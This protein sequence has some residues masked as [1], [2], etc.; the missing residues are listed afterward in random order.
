MNE[1][2]AWLKERYCVT[3]GKKNL[4]KKL[5]N[6]L[7]NMVEFNDQY[8]HGM[9]LMDLHHKDVPKPERLVLDKGEL[10]I[11]GFEHFCGEFGF[12]S[13]RRDIKNFTRPFFT[14]RIGNS[15]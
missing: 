3:T 11:S 5:K 2:E 15:L 14:N 4:P 6:L 9:M 7:N 12:H 8:E 1:T 13:I 10:D